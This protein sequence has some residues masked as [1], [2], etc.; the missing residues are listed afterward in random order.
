MKKFGL[1]FVTLAALVVG[2]TS[3]STSVTE[4]SSVQS[5]SSSVTPSTGGTSSTS[6]E[7]STTTSTTVDSTT[8]DSSTTDSSSVDS[9]TPDPVVYLRVGNEAAAVAEPG[10]LFYEVTGTVDIV[11]IVAPENGHYVIRYN[12]TGDE[13]GITLWYKNPLAVTGKTYIIGGTIEA[14]AVLA[15]AKVNGT[16]YEIERNIPLEFTRTNQLEKEGKASLAIVLLKTNN[17]IT[18]SG[19]S[20]TE[21]VYNEAPTFTVDGDYADWANTH[22]EENVRGVWGSGIYAHKS[23]VISAHLKSDGLYLFASAEHDL[24]VT[25]SGSWYTSTNFEFFINGNNQYYVTARNGGG[26]SGKV[27]TYA[28]VNVERSAAEIEGGLAKYHTNIEVFVATANITGA[29]VGNEI[30]VGVGWKT[31]GDLC[32]NGEAAAGGPDAYWVPAGGWTNG[33][34]K[35]VTS[36][37][38]SLTSSINYVPETITVDG[39]LADWPSAVLEKLDAQVVGTGISE[40]KDATWYAFIDEKGVYVGLV[41]HHSLYIDDGAQWHTSTN[42]EFFING[43]N[44]Y[45]VTAQGGAPGSA[46]KGAGALVTTGE[47][48]AYTTVGEWFLPAAF[49][50]TQITAGLLRIGFAFKTT[51]DILVGGGGT[52]MS[53]GDDW[54]YVAGHNPNT[55]AQQFYVYTD[56]VYGSEKA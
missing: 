16:S 10:V 26:K 13:S 28:I 8:A 40:G 31:D 11:S 15:S 36:N 43:N 35:F 22:S 25:D 5:E 12:V 45:Y 33:D 48:G 42:L 53:G 30:Q 51:G 32:N 54:W 46:S 39:N 27:D 56:G 52:G 34:Q 17:Q 18:L 21:K 44:Q 1:M 19:L 55:L 49:Y 20:F 4:S 37:G 47:A 2:C 9:S 29:I 7:S 41:A 6:V 3:V 14:S 24:Y 38:F 50:Q 23:V